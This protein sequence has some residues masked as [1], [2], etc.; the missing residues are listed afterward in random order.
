VLCSDARR[1]LGFIQSV[2]AW[3]RLHM[4][5]FRSHHSICYPSTDTLR[6]APELR[7]VHRLVE[8]AARCRDMGGY[9]QER[10]PW[11]IIIYL[12]DIHI[13]RYRRSRTSRSLLLRESV[14]VFRKPA[15]P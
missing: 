10:M 2:D 6:S 14:V 7:D 5:T 13:V 1:L 8:Q 11:I 4:G 12:V 3:R 15:T 9:A